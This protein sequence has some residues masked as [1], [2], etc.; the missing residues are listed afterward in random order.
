VDT[1]WIG[2]DPRLLQ[3]YGW[4]SWSARGGII[5]IRN[6]SDK[7]QAMGIDVREALEL[8]DDAPRIFNARNPFAVGRGRMIPSRFI[9]TQLQRVDL[10]PFEVLTLELTP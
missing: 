7:V 8:P 6:P 2:G 3:P 5:T 9:S 1:H 4:A 10:Q